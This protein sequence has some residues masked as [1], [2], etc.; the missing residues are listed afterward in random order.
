MPIRDSSID[1]ISDHYY[2]EPANFHGDFIVGV[3][4]SWADSPQSMMVYEH[5]KPV[6]PVEHVMAFVG[7]L[8]RH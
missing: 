1:A 8:G 5:V 7:Q 6:T 3:P 4:R 2:K